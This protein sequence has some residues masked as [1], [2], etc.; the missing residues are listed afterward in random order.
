MI[1]WRCLVDSVRS[2]LFL[3]QMNTDFNLTLFVGFVHGDFKLINIDSSQLMLK[4]VVFLL[5]LLFSMVVVF[6][7]NLLI[8][9]FQYRSCEYFVRFGGA[10]VVA[11][12]GTQ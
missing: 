6:V 10:Y 9:S 12:D 2:L 7:F 1:S 5:I 3:C 4:I 11:V 8:L